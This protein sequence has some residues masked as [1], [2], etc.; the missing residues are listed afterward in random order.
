MSAPNESIVTNAASLLCGVP[1]TKGTPMMSRAIMS[2]IAA[3]LLFRFSG[4]ADGVAITDANLPM[5]VGNM[6][7]LFFL[8][9]RDILRSR[10]GDTDQGK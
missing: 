8:G 6:G 9:L 7:I 5:I 3:G 2:V 1:S 10:A 4:A